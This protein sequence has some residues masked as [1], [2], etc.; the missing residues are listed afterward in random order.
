MQVRFFSEKDSSIWE[1]YVKNCPSATIAHQIG[2]KR[3]IEE[4]YGHSSCYLIAKNQRIHGV[5]PLILIR[6]PFMGKFLISVPFLDYGGICADTEETYKLLLNK[7]IELTKDY[8]CKYLELRNPSECHD[9]LPTKLTKAVLVLNL[10][11]DPERVWNTL[12]CKVRNQ[13]RKALKMGL[14]AKIEEDARNFKD[15]Y[16]VF[17][18]NMRDIGVPA[19]PFSFF[20]SIFNHFPGQTKLVTVFHDSK[21]I[22]GGILCFFKQTA[23]VPWASCLRNYFK[24]CPNHI[25]YWEAIKYSCIREFSSFDFGRSTIESG[26]F[27]FKKQWGADVKQLHWKYYLNTIQSIPDETSSNSKYWLAVKV[28]RKLPVGLTRNLGAKIVGYLPGV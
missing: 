10:D 20:K 15:F 2:W 18:R 23:V 13:I 25:L 1:D 17:A 11:P 14:V 26:T 8:N 16:S 7:A 9:L 19:L 28:W 6:N 21:I 22:G 3:V 5:L 4:V 12:D 27:N 24:M